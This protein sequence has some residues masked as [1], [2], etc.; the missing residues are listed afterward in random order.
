M[1]V[2]DS[3]AA[4]D[5]DPEPY[6]I[7]RVL[8][9]GAGLIGT[10]IGLAL[11]QQ[12]VD[13]AL[14]DHAP[15]RLALATELGAGRASVVGER[16]DVAVV[17]VPPAG[18]AGE[19]LRLQR[20]DL[21][22]T[23]TDVA[24]A[25]AEP[26]QEAET[27]GVDMSTYVG[28]HPVAGRE[29]S[30]PAAAHADLF[31]GRPWVITSTRA[32][33]K[34]AVADVAA[35]ARA[36]G[37]VPVPMTADDHDAALATVS[38]LPHLVASLLAAQ[39]VGSD[40]ATVALGG[41]GL[42]D[43][44]RVAAGDPDLWTQILLANADHLAAALSGFASDVQ[45]T[46]AD[47][48]RIASGDRAAATAL[49][50]TL[51]RGAAGRA[52]VPVKRGQPAAGF[53]TVPIVVRDAPGELASVLRTLGDAGINLEDVRVEH[54]PGRARG[55]VELDVRDDAAAKLVAVMQAAG[56]EVYS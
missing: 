46:V 34:Q 7:H 56:W 49:T 24:S 19:L 53:V 37:A 25:K 21:A 3:D 22:R 26:Q 15:G 27:A 41:T 2:G 45:R 55:V 50:E 18:V 44:T 28:G 32:A 6:G 5:R 12:F 51:R 11:R 29:R 4:G 38:H 33:T 20:L 39:L 35:L 14:E 1:S 8:I 47:L 10:S 16:F 43:T 17:A 23:Y 40:E 30:G 31:V 42:H 52:R 9:V 48:Q 54:E 36:C 13:V